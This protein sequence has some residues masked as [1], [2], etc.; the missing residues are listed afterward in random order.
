[1]RVFDNAYSRAVAVAKIVLPLVALGILSSLFLLSRHAPQGEPIEYADLTV[2][3]LAREQ[4]LGAPTYRG[5]TEEGAQVAL[6]AAELRPDPEQRETILGSDLVAE[7]LTQSGFGY[8]IT[9]LRGSIDQ[10]KRLTTLIGDV[11]IETSNGYVITTGAATMRSNLTELN[12]PGP[13]EADGPMGTLQAGSLEMSGDPGTGT[14]AV[15]V[16]KDGVRLV[17]TPEP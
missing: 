9:A 3:D 4:R 17:Y 12:T 13:V 6:S 8:T 1:M 15:V 7:I 2:L 10:E 5:V 14:G 11:R 16:F